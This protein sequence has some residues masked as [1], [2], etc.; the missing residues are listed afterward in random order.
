MR[1]IVQADPDAVVGAGRAIDPATGVEA[2]HLAAAQ[3]VAAPPSISDPPGSSPRCCPKG[4]CGRRRQGEPVLSSRYAPAPPPM[5]RS[6]RRHRTRCS[7]DS[8]PAARR[9][10]V[11]GADYRPRRVAGPAGRRADRTEQCSCARDPQRE[12]QHGRRLPAGARRRSPR[13]PPPRASAGATYAGRNGPLILSTW[14]G[15]APFGTA[16]AHVADCYGTTAPYPGTRTARTSG[17]LARAS[18]RSCPRT[19]G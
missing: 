17:G 5:L 4:R 7:A 18:S 15:I 9:N 19:G 16:E 6:L 8:P 11:S 2:D 3:P 12:Q 13:S 1:G 10:T 14:E